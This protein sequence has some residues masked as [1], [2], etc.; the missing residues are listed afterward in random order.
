MPASLQDFAV[1]A[2]IPL[3]HLKSGKLIAE[4]TGYVAFGT[5][6]WKLFQKLDTMRDGARVAVLIYP[7]WSDETD[8][9]LR[10]SWFGWYEGHSKGGAHPDGMTH[11]PPSTDN[12][13]HYAAFWHVSGLRQLLQAKQLPISKIRTIKGVWR[14]DAP[15]RGPE[16][17]ALPESLSNES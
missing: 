1:L 9:E 6:N 7:S 15:P 14:K 17:V 8:K 5:N 12:E 16:L 13:G 11:R 4:S 3:K 2:P 10:V